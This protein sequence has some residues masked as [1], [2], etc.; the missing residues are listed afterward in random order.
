MDLEFLWTRTSHHGGSHHS[1]AQLG[2]ADWTLNWDRTQPPRPPEVSMCEGDLQW[3][4]TWL[5]D[6]KKASG[7]KRSVYEAIKLVLVCRV[8]FFYLVRKTCN[9][10]FVCIL[11][12]FFSHLFTKSELVNCSHYHGIYLPGEIGLL[13]YKLLLQD[14]TGRG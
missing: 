3:L 1:L 6:E 4:L 9:S 2:L 14:R 7:D 13:W 8:V 10:I 12:I 5:W 11:S